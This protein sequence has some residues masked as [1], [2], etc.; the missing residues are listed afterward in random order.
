MEMG[1]PRVTADAGVDEVESALR[2]AGC[3]VVERLLPDDV[4]DRIQSDLEPFPL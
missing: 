2:A 1:V 3:V 4:M